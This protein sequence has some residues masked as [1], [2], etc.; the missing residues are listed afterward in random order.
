MQNL[1]R[2]TASDFK[3]G[4]VLYTKEGYKFSINEHYDEGIWNTRQGA[5]VFESEAKHYRVQA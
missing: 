2:A 5:V 3:I 1:R 4:T